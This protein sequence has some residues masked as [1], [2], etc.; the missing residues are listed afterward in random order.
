MIHLSLTLADIRAR[1]E[2]RKR[3]LAEN[4]AGITDQL[5]GMGALQVIVFGSFAEGHVRSMSD[6]DLIAVMPP[7]RT[8]REWRRFVGEN[9]ERGVG[10]DLLV[11]TE[12]ELVEMLPVSRFLRHALKTGRMVYEKRPET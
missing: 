9:I 10:C 12:E 8:G 2:R 6:L 11:Y 4:L 3:L 5:A 7:S 1:K